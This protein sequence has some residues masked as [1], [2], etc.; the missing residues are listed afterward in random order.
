VVLRGGLSNH[1]LSDLL[2]FL[3]GDTS[4]QDQRRIS[5][6]AGWPDGRRKFGTVAA[7][8]V[9]VLSL[10]DSEMRVKAI[11]GE[12]ER[13]LGGNVSRYS[14]SDYLRVRSKGPKAL[15]VRT[16]RGYYRLL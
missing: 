1:P 10:T 8:I 3:T 4:D 11:H 16:R 6:Q 7:A 2:Q 5:P 9:S 13:V 12:V 14:V 15:F